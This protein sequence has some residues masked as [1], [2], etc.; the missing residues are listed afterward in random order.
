MLVRHAGNVCGPPHISRRLDSQPA[1]S[2]DIK[3]VLRP[4]RDK[5][6]R[7]ICRGF[8]QHTS[9]AKAKD[10]GLLRGL[11]SRGYIRPSKTMSVFAAAFRSSHVVGSGTGAA[12][13]RRIRHAAFAGSAS[14]ARPCGHA[15]FMLRFLA[16]GGAGTDGSRTG[17]AGRGLILSRRNERRAEQRRHDKSRDCKFGSHQKYLSVGLQDLS[18]PWRTIWFRCVTNIAKIL[19]D[20]LWPLSNIQEL[21]NICHVPNTGFAQ[22]SSIDLLDSTPSQTSSKT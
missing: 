19:R 14:R 2:T 4:A 13:I 7:V 15:F 5:P 6:A 10:P 20:D 21:T 8:E 11:C 1:V 18:K 17:R 9:E 3:R 22:S 16:R 12:L